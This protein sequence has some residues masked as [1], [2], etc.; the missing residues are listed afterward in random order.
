MSLA[1]MQEH[2]YLKYKLVCIGM[3]TAKSPS[4]SRKRTA[5]ICGGLREFSVAWSHF[6]AIVCCNDNGSVILFP[7]SP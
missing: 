7:V 5:G 1:Y 4:V 6:V 2:D 3:P